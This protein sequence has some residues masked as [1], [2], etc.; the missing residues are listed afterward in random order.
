MWLAASA[1]K[2]SRNSPFEPP[3]GSEGALAFA[4]ALTPA[5][6]MAP[7]AASR[8]EKRLASGSLE[9]P[10]F[11][12]AAGLGSSRERAGSAGLGWASGRALLAGSWKR[13][14]NPNE[15][16]CEMPSST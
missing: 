5:S 8:S 3:D 9:R 10:K 4:P 1:V 7:N 12:G 13:R 6:T 16:L 11:G 14:S 15:G 2:S